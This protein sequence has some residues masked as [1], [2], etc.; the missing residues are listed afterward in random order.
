MTRRELLPSSRRSPI[1]G[2]C[3]LVAILR[4]CK[5]HLLSQHNQN[6]PANSGPLGLGSKKGIRTMKRATLRC[7]LGMLLLV[8][9]AVPAVAQQGMP[10]AKAAMDVASMKVIS[11]NANRWIDLAGTAIKM[12]NKKDLFMEISLQCGLFKD[13]ATATPIDDAGVQVRVL[14]NGVEAQARRIVY[15]RK[16]QALAPFAGLQSCTNSSG[17]MFFS[18]CTMSATERTSVLRSVVGNSFG[19][20]LVD[21]TPGVYHIKVQARIDRGTSPEAGM[22]RAVVGKGPATVEDVRMI[23]HNP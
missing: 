15:C 21:L 5:L 19:F 23:N 12:P 22:I 13:S 3:T 17:E 10:S 11:E 1:E 8:A 16:T 6:F 4:K 20:V 18:S 14:V 9:L 7:L 2:C